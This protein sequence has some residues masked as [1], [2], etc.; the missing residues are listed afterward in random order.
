MLNCGAPL[1]RDGQ[2]ELS[3]RPPANQ[4]KA[5]PA[6]KRIHSIWTRPA[7]E[8][9]ICDFFANWEEVCRLYGNCAD[10]KLMLEGVDGGCECDFIACESGWEP[11]AK[12]HAAK[13]QAK[14]EASQATLKISSLE[15]QVADTRNRLDQTFILNFRRKGELRHELDVL[16]QRLTE[17][18]TADDKRHGTRQ[19][20]P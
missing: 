17:Q 2:G 19:P 11:P 10:L 4:S 18:Q 14:L 20:C 12:L 15:H 16:R 9:R 8:A 5:G 6:P 13:L 3:S 7:G 1:P